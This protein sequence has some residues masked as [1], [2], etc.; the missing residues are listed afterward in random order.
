MLQQR[1]I[2]TFVNSLIYGT[3]GVQKHSFLL[4]VVEYLIVDKNWVAWQVVERKLVI[5]VI[6]N[7]TKI[8]TVN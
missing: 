4:F 5:N 1:N 7:Y 3:V 2:L 6:I 8:S